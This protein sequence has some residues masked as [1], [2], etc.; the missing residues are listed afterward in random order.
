M[1]RVSVN[2]YFPITV[3]LIDE[4]TGLP[5]TGKSVYYDI[6]NS[7]DTVNVYIDDVIISNSNIC[8][9]IKVKDFTDVAG[10]QLSLNYDKEFMNFENGIN[11]LGYNN[12]FFNEI[13]GDEII[14]ICDLGEGTTLP[15][16]TT[17]FELCF[18]IIGD[19]GNSYLSFDSKYDFKPGFFD[20]YDPLPFVLDNGQLGFEIGCIDDPIVYF[21]A[22]QNNET[23]DLKISVKNFYLGESPNDIVTINGNEYINLNCQNLGDNNYKINILHANGETDSCNVNIMVQDTI[24]PVVIVEPY[25]QVNLSINDYMELNSQI[26]DDG[27]WD[28]CGIDSISISPAIIDCD[29]DNP[30]YVEYKVFDRSGNVNSAI[31]KVHIKSL[32][33][34]VSTFACND[35]LNVELFGNESRTI[36]ADMILEGNYGCN[37]YYQLEIFEGLQ[38]SFPRSNNTVYPADN[39]KLLPARVV[40]VKNQLVCWSTIK[41]SALSDALVLT[42]PDITVKK[43]SSFF[44]D[45]TADRFNNISQS[46]I[47]IFWDD[48][49]ISFDSIRNISIF[50][51]F[52]I[53]QT[54]F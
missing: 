42:L 5:A 36:T 20:I 9:P 47:N 22:G 7:D 1:I 11:S 30:T 48:E 37:V 26:F 51:S 33:G 23:V 49:I 16:N 38:Y 35:T 28:N 4:E 10:F 2:E 13:N 43:D 39:N 45:L 53:F 24:P 41:V 27:S 54:F 15:D 31:S 25:I 17:L 8:I 18:E 19:S 3:T 12:L 44:V 29:T 52:S 32:N 6:R 46:I 14:I 34:E 40:N 50:L 21:P